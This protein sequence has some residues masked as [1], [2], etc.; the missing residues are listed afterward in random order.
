MLRK[1]ELQTNILGLCERID[2]R[3]EEIDW[4][5]RVRF[6]SNFHL[7]FAGRRSLR[8]SMS[9]GVITP[10]DGEI[11][12]ISVWKSASGTE[13]LAAPILD[14]FAPSGHEADTIAYACETRAQRGGGAIPDADRKDTEEVRRTG[15]DHLLPYGIDDGV[16][17]PNLRLLNVGKLYDKSQYITHTSPSV[18]TKIAVGLLIV[19]FKNA[20]S[21]APP[22]S[23]PPMF[24]VI[25]SMCAIYK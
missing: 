5:R 8:W 23:V 2:A 6:R 16:R 15:V 19:L 13:K 11:A 10:I 17:L 24:A 25:L 4:L 3:V 18:S 22:I 14:L 12:G 9:N 21:R 1:L 20:Q 7:S